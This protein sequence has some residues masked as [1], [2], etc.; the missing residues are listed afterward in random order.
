MPVA[1]TLK[2]WGC[3]VE[4]RHAKARVREMGLATLRDNSPSRI[5]AL[6]ALPVNYIRPKPQEPRRG[7]EE[8][9]YD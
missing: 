1:P 9:I 7:R 5:S 3:G 4:S 2:L 8:D 6:P